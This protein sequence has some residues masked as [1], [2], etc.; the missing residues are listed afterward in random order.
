MVEN[1]SQMAR[2]PLSQGGIGGP[3]AQRRFDEQPER[4]WPNAVSR[5]SEYPF[6]VLHDPKFSLSADGAFFCM[7]SCFAN[8]IE[9]HLIFE[10]AP[11]VMAVDR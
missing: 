1:L 2:G 3:E 11:L 10:G 7:G 5:F 4:F 6:P 9:E 8:N